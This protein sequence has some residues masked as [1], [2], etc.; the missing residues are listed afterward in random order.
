MTQPQPQPV[1]DAADDPVDTISPEDVVDPG[2]F[3][4]AD[5]EG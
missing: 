5:Q 1:P 2:D 3:P 4:P